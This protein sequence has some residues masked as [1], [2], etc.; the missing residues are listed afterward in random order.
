MLVCPFYFP[1]GNENARKRPKIHHP[2]E[3]CSFETYNLYVHTFFVLTTLFSCQLS[4]WDICH[5]YFSLSFVLLALL[6]LGSLLGHLFAARNTSL[7][8]N[9]A[10]DETDT[11]P[12]HLRKAMAKRKHGQ[13]H[14]EHFT[15]DGNSDE[16][17]G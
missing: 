3:T 13:N 15:S 12:L 10:K 8:A 5:A 16:K 11:K 6:R 14:G 2:F 1:K 17:N 4:K 9:T 7:D